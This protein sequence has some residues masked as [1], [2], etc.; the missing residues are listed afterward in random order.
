MRRETKPRLRKLSSPALKFSACGK[1]I[2]GTGGGATLTWR[3]ESTSAGSAPC[4]R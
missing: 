3:N 1:L 4:V 2:V